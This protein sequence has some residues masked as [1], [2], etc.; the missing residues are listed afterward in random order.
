MDATIIFD[1][2]T[3]HLDS[4]HH[5]V[6]TAAYTLMECEIEGARFS[7]KYRM[8]QWNGKTSFYHRLY[9]TFPSGLV[10]MLEQ[11]LKTLG[12][13][14]EVVDRRA[15]LSITVNNGEVVACLNGVTL[16]DYQVKAVE[17]VFSAT[18]GIVRMPTGCHA[19]GT[20]ILMY[21]GSIKNVEDIC[22]GNIIM[23]PL[24]D[25]RTVLHLCGGF[26]EMY[27]I[28]PKRGNSWIVNE[29][30]ILTLVRSNSRPN[31]SYASPDIPQNHVHLRK[32]GNI[33]DVPLKEWIKWSKT[34]KHL[35]KLFKTPI[36]T[37]GGTDKVINID[38]YLIGLFLGDGSLGQ[39]PPCITTPDQEI[40]N[41]LQSTADSLGMKLSRSDHKNN[42]SSSYY[43]SNGN[44]GG[45]IKNPITTALEELGLLGHLSGTKFIPNVIKTGSEQ[46]R[47]NALAGLLDTDGHLSKSTEYDL[48]SKSRTLAEDVVFVSRSLGFYASIKECKKSCKLTNRIFN[49]TYYRVII[50]GD[51]DIIPCKVQRKKY[52]RIT[53]RNKN[54]L[55]SGFSVKHLGSGEYFGFKLDGDGRYLL[56][57]FTVT[58][59]SGKTKVGIAA[60]KLALEKAN[61][62]SLFLTHK[63]DLLHQTAADISRCVGVEVGV[64]GDGQKDFDRNITV[65]TVQTLSRAMK[66]PKIQDFLKSVRMIICDE[67]HHASAKTFKT[68]IEQC[69][70][71]YYRIGLTATPLMKTKLEDLQ[72]VAL[73]GEIIHRVSMQE[74]IDRGFLAQPLVKFIPVSEPTLPRNL[75]WRDAYLEGVVHNRHRNLLVTNEAAKFASVGLSTL[76]LINELDHGNNI[77]ELLEGYRG[78]RFRYISGE[79]SSDLRKSAF[80][81]I[82][83]GQIDVLL[84]STILD[85]GVDLPSVNAVINAG[86]WKS[87]VRVY[88]KIGR[89]MRPKASGENVVYIVDFAD[90]THRHL[91]KHSM[92]RLSTVNNEEG[93]KLVTDFGLVA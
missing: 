28:L 53:P 30:H 15:P 23:G 45:V 83:M 13:S 29:D 20:K 48:V 9:R 19:K 43:I 41:Y 82:A 24:G 42:A 77:A 36:K 64:V 61:A 84:S 33:V 68:V 85:E 54:C 35:H 47:L 60:M 89:G 80:D 8:G 4:P 91:I 69:K 1:E 14:V 59:N 21:D 49:G 81:E 88:Q 87:R 2:T 3:A 39:S 90:L 86:G 17:R 31:S 76:I 72:L 5:E 74:L 67:C 78:L 34:Q 70:A 44:T 7:H 46:T 66:D 56:G 50:S 38:P 18:S 62:T 16:R 27:E 52:T 11:Q 58:H 10:S 63:K 22:A 71:A 92:E 12:Y 93:F 73:T 32:N 75:D 79:D 25:P 51:L 57:D 65:A 55:R 26:G 40:V 6:H 37:F